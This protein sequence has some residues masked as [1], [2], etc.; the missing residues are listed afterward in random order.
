MVLVHQIS[1]LLP[2]STFYHFTRLLCNAAH[3]IKNIFPFRFIRFPKLPDVTDRLF[4]WRTDTGIADDNCKWFADSKGFYR[5][6]LYKIDRLG[7]GDH[8]IINSRGCAMMK[9]FDLI[10]KSIDV[11]LCHRKIEMGCKGAG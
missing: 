5:L 7:I 1:Q 9:F 4:G 10:S 2:L 8:S 11:L 6:S 3:F